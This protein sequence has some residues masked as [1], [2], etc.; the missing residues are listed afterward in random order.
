MVFA[1]LFGTM[2]NTVAADC[3]CCFIRE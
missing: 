2:L 1:S 3:R